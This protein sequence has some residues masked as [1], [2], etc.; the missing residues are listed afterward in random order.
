MYLVS[1]LENYHYSGKT[2]TRID[3]Y[4]SVCAIVVAACSIYSEGIG[5]VRFETVDL[6]VCV[7]VH[8]HQ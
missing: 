1:S 2:L 3:R 4:C 6:R 7:L 5:A 8:F